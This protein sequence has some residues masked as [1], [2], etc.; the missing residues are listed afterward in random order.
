MPKPRL[1][2]HVGRGAKWALAVVGATALGAVT[3][4]AAGHMPFIGHAQSAAKSARHPLPLPPLTFSVVH[5]E[6]GF[7]V[8]GI[9]RQPATLAAMKRAPGCNQ[10]ER[11][12][13]SGGG[14]D[15]SKTTLRVLVHGHR[16]DDVTITG[17][18]ATVVSRTQ[19][20]LGAEAL[21]AGGGDV[22]DIPIALDLESRNPTSY[23][24]LHRVTTVA[25]GEVASFG[26]I[27]RTR[28]HVIAW[29]LIVSAELASGRKLT[30][31][32][33][34]QGH[35]FRTTPQQAGTPVYE[36]RWWWMAHKKLAPYLSVTRE[37]YGSVP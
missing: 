23:H 6:E 29:K 14:G 33:D 4:A 35:P 19:P 37:P 36:W 21:C 18:R 27:A 34:D 24:F 7:A 32:L 31:V 12:A 3:L 5:L 9:P 20:T 13:R 15:P 16:A 2:G 26:I 28:S 8:V 10:L 17:I 25:K 1:V 22:G 11:T 30:Y